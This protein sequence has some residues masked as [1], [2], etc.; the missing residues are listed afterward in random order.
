V[1]LA[2]EKE[3]CWAGEAWSM[4]RPAEGIRELWAVS[5]P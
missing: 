3:L 5:T 4:T 1:K 2:C